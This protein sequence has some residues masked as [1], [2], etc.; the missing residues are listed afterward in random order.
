MEGN[1][2]RIVLTGVLTCLMMLA[3]CPAYLHGD[4][5]HV[6]LTYHFFHVNIFHLAGNLLSV[7]LI[8]SRGRRFGWRSF[9]LAYICAT[10]AWYCTSDSVAGMSNVIF[11]FLGLHTPSLKDAWWRQSSIL[12]FLAVTVGMVF[13]PGI[14][15]ETHIASFVMG[16]TCACIRRFISSVSRDYRRA[17]Y[18]Q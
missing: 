3:G 8:F 1:S 10:L 16:C 15:A 12:V 6:A 5:F 9:A 18:N 7:W 11:A 4:G 14:S 17:S 2:I 13:I